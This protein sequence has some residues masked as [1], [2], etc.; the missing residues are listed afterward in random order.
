MRT[1]IVMLTGPAG[2]GKDT[3]AS[4]LVKNHGA[5]AIAQA[6]PMKRLAM[7][8]F[9]FPEETLWGRASGATIARSSVNGTG[10]SSPIG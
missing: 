5:V 6:D 8:L 3:V 10:N 2:S 7:Q 9:E 4:F 1:P